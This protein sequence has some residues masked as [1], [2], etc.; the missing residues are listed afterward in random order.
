M[1]VSDENIIEMLFDR[2]EKALTIADN[3]Y[4]S[5]CRKLAYNIIGDYDEAGE[6]VNN[7]YF[8]LWNA[9]PP[10]RPECLKAYLCGIVRNLAAAISRKKRAYNENQTN[11][12]EL[13]EIFSD[14]EDT[15]EQFDGKMLGAYINEFLSGQ[16]ET[17]RK[18]F[19]M[20]YY[21]NFNI[22]DISL[23]LK[24]KEATVKT[25]L[26]RIRGELK[27]FLTEKGYNL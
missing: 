19:V 20:R 27:L 10:A 7:S 23:T 5:L 18:I 15:E 14:L 26:F 2:D 8:Q 25:K 1:I 13:S 3:K 24:M 22:R 17:N 12:S 4:G 16:K 9:I 6:C 11:F 21:Y